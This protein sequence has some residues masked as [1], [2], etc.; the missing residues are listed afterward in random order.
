MGKVYPGGETEL[1]SMGLQCMVQRPVE[2][3]TKDPEM[4]DLILGILRGL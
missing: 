3:A 4:F 2:L 1:L